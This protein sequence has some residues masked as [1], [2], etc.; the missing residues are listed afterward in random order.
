MEFTNIEKQWRKDLN[1]YASK[2][3]MEHLDMIFSSAQIETYEHTMDNYSM[4]S[5]FG[6]F[7]HKLRS[8]G[9]VFLGV[10]KAPW[11]HSG[12]DTAIVFED[13]NTFQ[14]Y[15]YHTNSYIIEWWQEQVALYTGRSLNEG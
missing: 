6:E 12:R 1:T 10:G 5:S 8:Q 7:L 2:E 3:E 9:Y 13:V 11:I 14:K 4:D 15:W